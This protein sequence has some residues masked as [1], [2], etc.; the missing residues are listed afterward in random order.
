[1]IVHGI[2]LMLPIAINQTNTSTQQ[3]A[4]NFITLELSNKIKNHVTPPRRQLSRT[5]TSSKINPKKSSLNAPS[6]GIKIDLSSYARK[7]YQAILEKRQYPLL[8]KQNKIE[9]IVKVT[10]MID[11]QGYLLSK[12]AVIQSSGNLLLDKEALRMVTVASPYEPLPLA[13][14]NDKATFQLAVQ[15]T[16]N[17]W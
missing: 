10:L 9:G 12:P 2:I 15:F 5:S 3:E 16:L 6:S 17:Q 11:R 7:I 13:W 4:Q 8:A 1:M 14:N